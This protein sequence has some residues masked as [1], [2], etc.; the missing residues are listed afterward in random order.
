MGKKGGTAMPQQETK[1]ASPSYAP[2]MTR[3][4]SRISDTTCRVNAEA[5]PRLSSYIA[6]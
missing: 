6:A 1:G 3:D 5:L 2:T 4:Y